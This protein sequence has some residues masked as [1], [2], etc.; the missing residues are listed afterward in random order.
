MN[1][2]PIAKMVH[3]WEVKARRCRGERPILLIIMFATFFENL[4]V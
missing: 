3:G 1:D 4:R 2:I